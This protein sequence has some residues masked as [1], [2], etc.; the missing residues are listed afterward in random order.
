SWLLNQL[1]ETRA[2]LEEAT[3][4]LQRYE[5]DHQILFVESKAGV[6]Q[7]LESERLE[8]LQAN[9]IHAQE[10][11]IEKESL[12]KRAQAGDVSVL[13][14][15]LLNDLQT[16]ETVLEQKLSQVSV[17]FGPNFPEVKQAAA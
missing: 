12:N 2:K 5:M 1:N 16:K 17:K 14:D 10:L 13:R 11:R 6:P 3:Q 7:S 8:Q 15:P 4:S 9:L